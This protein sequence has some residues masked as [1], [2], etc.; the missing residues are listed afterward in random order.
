[1]QLRHALPPPIGRSTPGSSRTSMCPTS[2]PSLLLDGLIRSLQERGRDR[3][4]TGLGGL[5]G[6]ASG[7]RT[8]L[9]ALWAARDLGGH[10]PRHV[11][12]TIGPGTR[13][14]A[15]RTKPTTSPIVPSKSTSLP[16]QPSMVTPFALPPPTRR[17]DL[18][19]RTGPS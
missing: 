3:Q 15:A 12:L 18:S 8:W 10:H 11:T 6:G 14:N 13:K 17:P 9:G 2:M 1:M 4:P 7:A 5:E 16:S 19:L